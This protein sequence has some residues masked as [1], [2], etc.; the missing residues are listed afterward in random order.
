MV[1][2]SLISEVNH[3]RFVSHHQVADSRFFAKTVTD[4]IKRTSAKLM[5]SAVEMKQRIKNAPERA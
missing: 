2:Q 5:K 1:A 4:S 3:I